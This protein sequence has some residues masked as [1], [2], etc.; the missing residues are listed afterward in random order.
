MSPENRTCWF[1][2]VGLWFLL[3]MAETLY[4]LWREKVLAPWMGD[5]A[6]RDVSVFTGSLVILLITLA[7]IG[8]IRREAH[9]RCCSWDSRG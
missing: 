7:C 4:G 3:M 2:A 6:A 1:R 8:Q 9:E 5:A